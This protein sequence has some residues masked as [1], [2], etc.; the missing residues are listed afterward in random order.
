MYI[1]TIIEINANKNRENGITYLF[2]KV[3][4]L[5]NVTWTGN[6]SLLL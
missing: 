6:H 4:R 1:Y 2:G 3:S 5:E